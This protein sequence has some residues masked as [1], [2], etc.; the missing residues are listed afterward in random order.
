MTSYGSDFAGVDDLDPNL[1]F[2][3]DERVAFAQAI[4]RRITTPRGRA[5]PDPG[6][7]GLFYRQN[8][9]DDIRNY[10]SSSANAATV[11]QQINAE[12][13]KD[14]RVLTCA[15]TITSIGVAANVQWQININ[16]TPKTGAPFSLTLAVGSVTVSLLK[17]TT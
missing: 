10:I 12:V 13:R 11:A 15:T 5:Q 8:Y 2:L 4:A 6:A 7:G 1:T 9:G 14:E 3:T 17:V 16:V